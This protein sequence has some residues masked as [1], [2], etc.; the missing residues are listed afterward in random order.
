[1]P[2]SHRGKHVIISYDETVCAHAGECVR[3]FPAIF[4]L[5]RT[6]WIEPGDADYETALGSA[7]A[8]PS[9]ALKV[10]PISG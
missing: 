7:A 2:E 4:D 10:T 6:P 3:R 5:G 9:G 8:C 1:M